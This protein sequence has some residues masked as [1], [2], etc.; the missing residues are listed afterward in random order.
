VE[1]RAR[2]RASDAVTSFERGG[3]GVTPTNFGSLTA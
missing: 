2:R 1:L 3:D